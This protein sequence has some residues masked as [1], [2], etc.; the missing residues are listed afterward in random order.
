MQNEKGLT[1][2]EVLVGISI[3]SIIMVILGG[4][5]VNG[6]RN[7]EKAENITSL[8]QEANLIITELKDIHRQYYDEYTININKASN[9]ITVS[10]KDQ[11]KYPN[12]AFTKVIADS[13]LYEYFLTPVNVPIK[14]DNEQDN[15]LSIKL[16]IKSK[17]DPTLKSYTI[18]T[19]LSRLGGS[20]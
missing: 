8:Q 12:D 20:N 18:H 3:L 4:L 9:S 1:L 6:F 10:I 15:N 11:N 2:I 13:N 7:S 17:D 16:E 5:L 19:T 14:N